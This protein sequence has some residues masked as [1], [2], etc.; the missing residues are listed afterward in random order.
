[1]PDVWRQTH[2]TMNNKTPTLTYTTALPFLVAALWLGLPLQAHASPFELFGAGARSSGMSG[3]GGAD[4]RDPSATWSN[5]ALLTDPDQSRLTLGFQAVIPDLFIDRA[6][7]STTDANGGRNNLLPSTSAGI[8]VGGSWRLETDSLPTVA[9]GALLYVPLAGTT[10][11]EAVDPATPHFVL[12][13]SLTDRLSVNA[14]AAIELWPQRLSMAVGFSGLVGVSGQSDALLDTER[15]KVLRRNF[16]A[17]VEAQVA[18]IAARSWRPHRRLTIGVTYR[19]SLAVPYQ[20]PIEFVFVDG[21]RLDF[22]IEGTSLY[23]P[24]QFNLAAAWRGPLWSLMIEATWARWSQAPSPAADVV[25]FLDNSGLNPDSDEVQRLLEFES[26]PISAGFVDTITPKIGVE[27]MLGPHWTV[28]GGYSLR[29]TPVPNQ[30]GYSNFLDHHAHQ[31]SLGATW[32]GGRKLGIG[33]VSAFVQCTLLQ[34]RHT[35]KDPE[36]DVLGIGDHDSGGVIW[37]QGLEVAW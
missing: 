36:R 8:T 11:L 26:I 34:T 4:T 35:N 13:Q 21:G 24:D 9:F 27:R 23:T 19:G 33:P 29:P 16:D 12:Y 20:L 3:A 17:D 6:P 31:L 30:V 25:T 22:F 32:R 14:A 5:P 18:P 37:N 10:R 1:M 28:R 7:S 15:R 2:D